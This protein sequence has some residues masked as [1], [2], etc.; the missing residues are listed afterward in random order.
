MS[1]SEFYLNRRVPLIIT[2]WL[3]LSWTH[4]IE[5][6]QIHTET[7]ASGLAGW[8]HQDLGSIQATNGSVHVTFAAQGGPPQPQTA[9]LTADTSASGGAFT[10]DYGDAGVDLIG[11]DF[12]ADNVLPSLLK[13]EW[14]AGTNTYFR[15]LKSHIGVTGAWHTLSVSLAGRAAG[16][17]QGPEEE[18]VF[19]QSLQSV[20]Q[21]V[22][23]VSRAGVASQRYRIDN[24]RLGRRPESATIGLSEN[25]IFLDWSNLQ[26]NLAYQV[27]AANTLTGEW[28][29]IGVYIAGEDV[30]F[31]VEPVPSTNAVRFYRLRQEE[32]HAP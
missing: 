13:L 27:Q 20:S 25:A 19:A 5:A 2:A 32:V 11:F 30:D 8:I 21:V 14:S 4:D 24:V 6:A 3:G 22:V 17:W 26:S 10:G 1:I 28:T 23:R 31:V 18:A 9:S 16:A 12:C 29:H 7:F 15:D